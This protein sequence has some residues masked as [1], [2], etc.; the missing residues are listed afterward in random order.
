MFLIFRYIAI[1]IDK[2]KQAVLFKESY[3]YVDMPHINDSPT[4]NEI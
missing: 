2:W 1:R 3:R 4:H